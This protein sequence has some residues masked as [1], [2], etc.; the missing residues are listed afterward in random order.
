MTLWEITLAAA[1][2]GDS[3]IA[4][5][6]L[7]FAQRTVA[8]LMEPRRALWLRRGVMLLA[9]LW[10]LTAMAQLIWAL[11]PVGQTR[12]LEGPVIN[13]PAEFAALGV[14][15]TQ[16]DIE[17]LR[18]WAL[19]GE[20]GGAVLAEPE[21]A[22]SE[23]RSVREG[24]ERGARETRLELTLRGIIAFNDAGEGSAI[25]EH[26]SRQAIYSVDDEL[27]VSGTV[28][29]AKVMPDQVVLDNGGTYELLRLYPPSALDT[30]AVGAPQAVPVTR[31]Q[32]AAAATVVDKRADAEAAALAAGYRDQLYA[33]PQS[34]A[35]LVRIAAVRADGALRGYRVTP[36][37]N[38]VQFE[39]LG[40]RAG[41]LVLAVNGLSLSDPA[42]TMRLY[43]AMRSA[44]EASFDL[45]R[46][47]ESV[48]LSV[49]LDAAPADQ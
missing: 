11:V 38:R 40:F 41:D 39:Q 15:R 3:I 35:D 10:V 5:K 2:L 9:L 45:L 1:S 12:A 22:V 21:P 6:V 44:T 29:L 4:G 48:A 20:P 33:D 30:Q 24:I 16:V 27:P 14:A 46:G 7:A 36:G 17:V 28:V 23:A 42:N 47:G 26:R 37:Q 32:P 49:S 25:I 18:A 43:Q 31:S 19:F 13:P 8:A 34:L